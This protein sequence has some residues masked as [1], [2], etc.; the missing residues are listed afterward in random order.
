M[1]NSVVSARRVELRGLTVVV[2]TYVAIAVGTVLA[3]ALLRATAPRLAPQEAWIHAVIVVVFAAVLPVRLRAA[4][5]GARSALRA[6][7][8]I[9]AVLLLANVVVA[10]VPGL[11][12]TWMRVEMI[13]IALLMSVAVLLVVRT[14]LSHE[15]AADSD[16]RSTS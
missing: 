5:R 7:G 1:V 12:P 11:L 14:A 9:A 6:V 10:L 8:I 4:R 15:A 16:R 3:L 13:G 2:R